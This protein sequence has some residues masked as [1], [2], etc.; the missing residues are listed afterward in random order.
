MCSFNEN[1]FSLSQTNKRIKDADLVPSLEVLKTCIDS[2]MK[3]FEAI[4]AKNVS[5]IRNLLK[6]KAKLTELAERTGLDEQ[7]LILLRR[8]IEGWIP[9]PVN[10]SDFFWLDQKNLHALE[11]ANIRTSHDLL[12]ALSL[13]DTKNALLKNSGIQEKELSDLENLSSL[14]NVRWISPNFAR[15]IHELGYT[16]QSLCSAD[17]QKLTQEIDSCNKEKGY[18]KGKVGERDVKRLIFEAQFAL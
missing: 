1:N 9:K 16:P 6:N 8:E 15:V 14:M 11:L 13:S 17:A 12:N 10:L 5:D 4:G 18:Y 3:A 7:K 2:Y